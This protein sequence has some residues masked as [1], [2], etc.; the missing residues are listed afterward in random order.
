MIRKQFVP[1]MVVVLAAWNMAAGFSGAR[2][3]DLSGNNAQEAALVHDQ[4][5][6]SKCPEP[7]NYSNLKNALAEAAASDKSGLNDQLY[8]T[9]VNHDG[10]VCAV[11]FSGVSRLAQPP[12]S[13]IFSA[14]K[15]STAN[16]FSTDG[17]SFSNGSGQPSGL[18]QSTANLYNNTQPGGVL[19]SYD[20]ASPVDTAVAYAGPTSAYG[21]PNDPMVGKIVG[22]INLT[23]GGVALYATG[24]VI[25][26][27]VGV[28]G[29]TP[30]RDHNIAW[31]VRH[32]M[33]LD[34]M[35]PNVGQPGV[36]G[37]AALFAGDTAHPDNII[38]DIT[39]NPNGGTGVSK[40]GFGHA[41]CPFGTNPLTLP[42]VQP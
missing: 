1:R 21:S 42:A 24:H 8:A 26:G 28:S 38:F 40:S 5:Q 10:V 31:L 4:H 18:A 12:S 17:T 6:S 19:W 37:P 41:A 27:A 36:A 22:G 7:L 30:C 14:V 3:Q 11:A 29:D 13:R 35:A 2:A 20:A 16:G 9:L 15:A 25:I 32:N 34:H 39:P 23:G 33:G